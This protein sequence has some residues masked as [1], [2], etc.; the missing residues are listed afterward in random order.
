MFLKDGENLLLGD[1]FVDV[2]ASYT[3]E[4]R[5]SFGAQEGI[6]CFSSWDSNLS[7]D[8]T[9]LFLVCL[10]GN[11][12]YEINL[13]E[14]GTGK[15]L[16]TIV[17]DY[18]SSV[19]YPSIRLSANGSLIAGGFHSLEVDIWDTKTGEVR[20]R[21]H[22]EHGV[23]PRRFLP[24]GRLVV[25]T[26]DGLLKIWDPGKDSVDLTI[27]GVDNAISPSGE[28]LA[29][30]E[31]RSAE[32]K[33]LNLKTNKTVLSVIT[34]ASSYNSGNFSPDSK[35]LALGSNDGKIV[36]INLTTG[37]ST[38]IES[39]HSKCICVLSFSPD[40][41]LLAAGSHDA[42][43]L[44]ILN[45]ESLSVVSTLNAPGQTLSF[46]PDGRLL[47]SGNFAKRISRLWAVQQP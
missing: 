30:T 45:I 3:L 4:K 7:A 8:E 13:Y 32:V 19:F 6:G 29:I 21:F 5:F 28:M 22:D 47:A 46:S 40:G 25:L 35:L 1:S 34:N 44:T 15:K 11:K 17:T 2:L 26:D 43:T 42:L 20:Y 33:I 37:E 16:K 14:V 27:L 41:R 10:G 24:D 39:G 23:S 31:W 12:N 36:L 18:V 9:T 38:K